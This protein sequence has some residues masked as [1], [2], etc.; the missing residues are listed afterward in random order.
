MVI[1]SGCF[2]SLVPRIFWGMKTIFEIE[3]FGDEF[4]QA[5]QH[6]ITSTLQHINTFAI[7]VLLGYL[8]VKYSN[9]KLK[10][11][12]RLILWMICPVMSLA[13]IYW[14]KNWFRIE[15]HPDDLQIICWTAFSKIVYSI[16]PFWVIYSCATGNAGIYCLIH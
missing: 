6:L 9:V 4:F 11:S 12:I 14:S 7:G 8:I 1:I 13:S 15:S 2:L 16:G 10:K 5:F 3:N